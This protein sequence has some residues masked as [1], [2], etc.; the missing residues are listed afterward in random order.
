M[1]WFPNKTVRPHDLGSFFLQ[2]K[3]VRNVKSFSVLS[4][5]PRPHQQEGGIGV[6]EKL[7]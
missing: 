2:L 3:R 7:E 6:S 1:N 5:D 4:L